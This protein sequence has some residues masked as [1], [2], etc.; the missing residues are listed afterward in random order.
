MSLVQR[1]TSH[2]KCPRNGAAAPSQDNAKVGRLE[3][4][5]IFSGI[6]STS[7]ASYM[8]AYTVHELHFF[9]PI[10]SAS[11]VIGIPSRIEKIGLGPLRLF[12]YLT[13]IKIKGTTVLR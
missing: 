8:S 12:L 11:K 4:H 10:L 1:K 3:A 9:L 6:T 5:A 7:T 2:S 13:E